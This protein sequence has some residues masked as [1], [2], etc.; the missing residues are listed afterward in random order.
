MTDDEALA[1]VKATAA[2]L[3]LALDEARTQ[4]V[5]AN[6]QR[7]AAMALMLEQYELAPHDELAEIYCPAP[8]RFSSD[9]EDTL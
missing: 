2:A 4:R 5:A 1:C 8:F 7:T 3:A 6:L 9:V